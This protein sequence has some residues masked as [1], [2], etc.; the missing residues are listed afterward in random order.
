VLYQVNPVTLLPDLSLPINPNN[1]T[2]RVT[3]NRIQKN[4]AGQVAYI[5][6]NAYSGYGVDDVTFYVQDTNYGLKS[7]PLNFKINIIPTHSVP[8]A[9]GVSG[10]VHVYDDPV[11]ILLTSSGDKG[12][13]LSLIITSFPATGRLYNLDGTPLASDSPIVT[14]PLGIVKYTPDK[15]TAGPSSFSYKVVDNTNGFSSPSVAVRLQLSPSTASETVPAVRYTD[16]VWTIVS[17]NNNSA[18]AKSQATFTVTGTDTN[19][20][21]LS[22]VFTNV[23]SVQNGVILYNGKSI[24][25]LLN[26]QCDCI[27]ISANRSSTG[28]SQWTFVYQASNPNGVDNTVFSVVD[29]QITSASDLTRYPQY[30][31]LLDANQAGKFTGGDGNSGHTSSSGG[32]G[33]GSRLSGFWIAFIVIVCIILC[34]LCITC[35]VLAI[36]L[37]KKRTSGGRGFRRGG[38]KPLNDQQYENLGSYSPPDL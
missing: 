7:K 12:D 29:R 26:Q 1:V 8:V 36:V 30:S 24:S 33:G 35:I 37:V 25:Q 28:Q 5:H 18:T 20:D 15:T 34:L 3:V 32:D 16:P 6:K 11:T 9:G 22:I 27:I 10:I 4:E 21:P 38:R 14:N 17:Q 13:N 19:N 2:T 31:I 23:P